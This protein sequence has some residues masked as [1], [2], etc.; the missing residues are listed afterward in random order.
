MNGGEEEKPSSS[1][2]EFS[3]H[4]EKFLSLIHI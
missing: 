1:Y 2:L 4:Q 3:L